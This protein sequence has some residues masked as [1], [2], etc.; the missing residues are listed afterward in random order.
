MTAIHLSHRVGAL[1]VAALVTV[2][3][4]ALRRGE[5]TRRYGNVLLAVLTL[6]IGLGITNVLA[7]L[8]LHVAV[9]HNAGAALLL[10]TVVFI[11]ARITRR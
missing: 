4:L 2:F 5:A 10:G 7:S 11:N 9:A 1:I 3:A 6:Q 8:P